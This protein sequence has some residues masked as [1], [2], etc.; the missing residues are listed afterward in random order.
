MALVLDILK[1]SGIVAG[2]LT[3]AALLVVAAMAWLLGRPID[4]DGKES[5]RRC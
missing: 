3:A 1:W 2:G 5:A 4:D